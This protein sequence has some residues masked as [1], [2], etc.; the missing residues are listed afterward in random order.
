[1]S[2]LSEGTRLLGCSLRLHRSRPVTSPQRMTAIPCRLRRRRGKRERALNP[3][4][5]PSTLEVHR[6]R[7][8]T[9]RVRGHLPVVVPTPSGCCTEH[10]TQAHT[11]GT[12]R[13]PRT[14]SGSPTHTHTRSASAVIRSGPATN[15]APSTS[16]HPC[17]TGA[18]QTTPYPSH[19]PAVR[20]CTHAAAQIRPAHSPPFRSRSKWPAG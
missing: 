17:R 10:Q 6:R 1:M 19:R 20:P 5:R 2:C 11:A 14:S 16:Q 13:R 9:H 15:Q 4:R 12:H 8:R 18:N 7:R 3:N